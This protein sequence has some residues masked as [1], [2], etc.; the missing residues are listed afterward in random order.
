MSRNNRVWILFAGLA[1]LAIPLLWSG[2]SGLTPRTVAVGWLL[3]GCLV[4]LAKTQGLAELLVLA[5]LLLPG[6]HVTLVSQAGMKALEAYGLGARVLLALGFHG[7][8]CSLAQQADDRRVRTLL[9]LGATGVVVLAFAWGLWNRSLLLSAAL[10]GCSA[11]ALLLLR[12]RK[13]HD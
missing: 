13:A 10:L 8:L 1:S 12:S 9:R 6:L 5:F 3:L 4:G 11:A 2:S 7:A